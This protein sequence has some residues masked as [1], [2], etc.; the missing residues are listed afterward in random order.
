MANSNEGVM[1]CL[2]ADGRCCGRKP[3]V[4]KRP[5]FHYFCSRCDREFNA[6]GN[7]V[8]NWAWKLRGSEFVR[9]DSKADG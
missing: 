6:N 3:L 1:Y 4:Y 8:P 5:Y 7:Q 9:K 2:D